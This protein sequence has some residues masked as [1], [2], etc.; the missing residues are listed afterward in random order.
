[1]SGCEPATLESETSLGVLPDPPSVSGVAASDVGEETPVDD[2]GDA[3]FQRPD[4][5]F[6]GLSLGELLWW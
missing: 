2:V 3:P 6:A 5:F 4:R 1:E